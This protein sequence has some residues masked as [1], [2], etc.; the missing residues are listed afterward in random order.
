M[1]EIL[2]EA[3]VRA[4]T[5]SPKVTGSPVGESATVGGSS[6]AERTAPEV[7]GFPPWFT[8]GEAGTVGSNLPTVSKG[9]QVPP[10]L[11]RILAVLVSGAAVVAPAVPA[12][13]AT[14]IP[15]PGP[16]VA[17]APDG[18]GLIMRDGGICNP[19]RMGC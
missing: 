14:A 12:S 19:L 7:K 8:G 15:Q 11:P 6:R 4:G 3:G 5:R 10:T 18:Q 1:V 17:P 13:A 16:I 9:P 2:A